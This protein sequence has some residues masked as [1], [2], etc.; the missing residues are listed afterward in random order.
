LHAYTQFFSSAKRLLG[1][2]ESIG[3]LLA[4]DYMGTVVG[5]HRNTL[6]ALCNEFTQRHWSHNY[7]IALMNTYRFSE[8]FLYALFVHYKN[9]AAQQLHFDLQNKIFLLCKYSDF[10][11]KETLNERVREL[12]SNDNALGLHF[13]KHGAKFR[14]KKTPVPFSELKQ[15]VYSHW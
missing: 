10:Q 8:Y 2:N 13:Q 6:I 4:Y 9:D 1:L 15:I 5:F 12:L 11:T 14:N 3:E 7:K